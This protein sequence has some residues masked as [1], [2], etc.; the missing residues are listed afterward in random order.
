MNQGRHRLLVD[1]ASLERQRRL[2]DFVQNRELR[3]RA[4]AENSQLECTHDFG[5]IGGR[6]VL[7]I[8]NEQVVIQFTR[9]DS[10]V[11]CA[12]S[13]N[14]VTRRGEFIRQSGAAVVATLDHEDFECAFRL[15]RHG[16]G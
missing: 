2:Y 1:A 7:Q 4:R 8:A 16:L 6:V 9:R 5:D 3:A 10:F 15:I 14:P 12:L 13:A 11:A